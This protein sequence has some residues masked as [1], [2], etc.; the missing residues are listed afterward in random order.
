MKLWSIGAAVAIGTVM[1]GQLLLACGT[2]DPGSGAAMAGSSSSAGSSAAGSGHGGQPGVA[3]SSSSGSASGGEGT[4]PNGGEPAAA[5]NGAG[6]EPATSDAPLLPWNV[7]NS[8]TYDVNKNGTVTEKTTVV[9]ALEV[10]GGSGP[11]AKLEAFHVTTSKG[12]GSN[13]HTESWQGADAANPDRILR[14]RELTYDAKTGMLQ[15]EVYC[16]PP[17]LHVDGSPEHTVKGAS[18]L[19]KYTETTLTVGS[20]VTS[21]AV[22]ERWTVLD[23]NE[24][25]AVPAGTFMHVIH[26]QKTGA[27]SSKDYWYAR[28]VGKL[29]ETGTQTEELVKY[30]LAP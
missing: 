2:A 12:A 28:G 17:K 22:S 24:T 25:L 14:F 11:S 20:P 1:A 21:H 5:G 7:G 18:W 29:K 4:S 15:D 3:G 9:G 10:V 30:S 16:D 8:W 6:G 13:D 19:E 26:L 23:D 27:A